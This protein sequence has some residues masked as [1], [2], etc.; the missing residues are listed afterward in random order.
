MLKVMISEQERQTLIKAAEDFVREAKLHASA[1]EDRLDE[2]R[3]AYSPAAMAIAG[4]SIMF[5]IKMIELAR[6][7]A[8]QTFGTVL[9][10]L[11]EFD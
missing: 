9:G 6:K 4:K 10:K 5:R 3:M 8:D 1:A 7:Y 2:L 11:W